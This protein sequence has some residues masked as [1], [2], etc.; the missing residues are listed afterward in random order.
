MVGDYGK[1]DYRSC[2]SL[3]SKKITNPHACIRNYALIDLFLAALSICTTARH[4]LHHPHYQHEVTT[5]IC[6]LDTIYQRVPVKDKKVTKE[7]PE[8]N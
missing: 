7:I 1:S 2:K 8:I 3:A 5:T 6:Q 4:G